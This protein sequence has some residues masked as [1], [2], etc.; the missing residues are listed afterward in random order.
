MSI[1]NSGNTS[2][3]ISQIDVTGDFFVQ[4]PVAGFP[5]IRPNTGPDDLGVVPADGGGD[6]PGVD[7]DP[8]ASQGPLPPLALTGEAFV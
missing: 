1:H 3:V 8:T 7:H 2:V 6:A 4:D 5:E